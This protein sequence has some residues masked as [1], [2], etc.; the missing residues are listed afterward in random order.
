MNNSSA[1]VGVMNLKSAKMYDC[2]IE[3]NKASVSENDVV[4]LGGGNVNGQISGLYN[5]AIIN[6]SSPN[7]ITTID[8]GQYVSISNCTTY[9]SFADYVDDTTRYEDW[10]YDWTDSKVSVEKQ[11]VTPTC[12]SGVLALNN[13]MEFTTV[14]L[15]AVEDTTYTTVLANATAIKSIDVRDFVISYMEK[16]TLANA[17]Y[18]YKVVIESE[19]Y[20]GEYT[21]EK[22]IPITSASEFDALISD[23]ADFNGTAAGFVGKFYYLTTDI[24][25]STY[26]TWSGWNQNGLGLNIQFSLDGRGHTISNVY[27]LGMANNYKYYGLAAYWGNGKV[28]G[29]AV[30]NVWK[31]VHY[32]VDLSVNENSAVRSI[33]GGAIS[34]YD[35]YNCYFEVNY[36]D[37]NVYDSTV[38][39]ANT[40][41][42]SIDSSSKM[43]NCIIEL[44]N[45][46]TKKASVVGYGDTTGGSYVNVVVINS[47]VSSSSVVT[48]V[49]SKSAVANPVYGYTSIANFIAGNE[50]YNATGSNGATITA[51]ENGTKCYSAWNSV[52]SITDGG[53]SLCGQQIVTIA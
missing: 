40:G 49:P 2:I 32:S 14:K 21:T 41:L 20:K 31:N 12:T 23:S 43:Y 37:N 6:S 9:G 16:Q 10:T 19:G 4:I 39:D 17:E 13:N 53:I 27:T 48:A 3:L 51:I 24:D 5:C 38:T 29:V 15:Y 44:N 46:G 36:T 50:G 18:Q 22:F 33:I 45:H 47:D 8:A 30:K 34:N 35:F 26:N 25:V 11:T 52:W 7:A 42:F 28:D 1:S